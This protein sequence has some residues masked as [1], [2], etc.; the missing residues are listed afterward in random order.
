MRAARPVPPVNLPA[1]EVAPEL[2]LAL[3]MSLCGAHMG[4]YGWALRRMPNGS[5]LLRTWRR[6]APMHQVGYLGSLMSVLT[7]QPGREQL[8]SERR[9]ELGLPATSAETATIGAL[10]LIL[11]ATQK[12]TGSG[13]WLD[14]RPWT[15]THLR[16]R[17][18]LP[19][20]D[21]RGKQTWHHLHDSAL[22][23]LLAAGA[24]YLGSRAKQ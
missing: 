6:G 11:F 12:G 4:Y 23:P 3:V 10:A 21:I 2:G 1:I 9:R 14:F 22:E 16:Y 8:T 5:F 24:A 13:A 18:R 15:A 7:H 20:L 19:E 17:L